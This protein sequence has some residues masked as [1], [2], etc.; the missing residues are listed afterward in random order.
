MSEDN[1]VEAAEVA[2][3]ATEEQQ[4]GPD[5]T[6]QDLQALKSI[7][8]VASQRGAF[9]PNEMMTVG[10]TYSKLETFLGAVAQQQPAQGA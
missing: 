4:A 8:D 2:A 5:L 9:K 7:I 10:Q 3:P 6:V 1:N